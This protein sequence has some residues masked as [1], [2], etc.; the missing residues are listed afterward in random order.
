M[1]DF[2]GVFRPLGD[3]IRAPGVKAGGPGLLGHGRGAA[4][5]LMD[6]LVNFGPLQPDVICV[7]PG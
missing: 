6:Y 2:E 4:M 7:K 1:V 5:W 3:L